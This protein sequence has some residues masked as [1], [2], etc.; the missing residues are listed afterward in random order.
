MEYIIIG[1]GVA[2]Q[3]AAEA[4]RK[5][6]PTTVITLI[7]KEPFGY[8]SRIFLP[9]YITRTKSL[10]NLILRDKAWYAQQNIRFL[11]GVTV[12]RIDRST[13]TV[14]TASTNSASPPS[15]LVNSYHYDKLL[16]ATGSNARKLPF[17]N[18]SV[19]GVFTLRNIADADEIYE[20]ITKHKV[21]EIFIIGGGLLGIELGY[22]LRDLHVHVTICEIA[23]Y[24]L[25]RQLDEP[26]AHILQ[27][28]L[29]S[30][31]LQI[32]TGVEVDRILGDQVVTGVRLKSGQE[33]PAGIVLQ[34]MGIIP[35]I[36]LA[37]SIG[38]PTDKGIIV[39]EYLQTIDNEIY[40]IGDC[41]QFRGLIWGI[42]PASLEQAKIA[43][44]HI[45]GQNPATYAGSFWNTRLK[46]AGIQLSCLGTP[47][48]GETPTLENVDEGN[49]LCK[50]V[51][52]D[53]NTLKSAILMEVGSVNDQYFVKNIGKKVNVDE[54]KKKLY[55]KPK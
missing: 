22:Q 20:Y 28:Y 43:V 29:E 41:V 17:S 36:A 37:K 32:L 13:H 30:Q 12:T 23:P 7:G 3:T 1:N 35:E 9:Q 50:K 45:L 10:T 31:Q 34:Q 42:I 15:S 55:D 14:Y 38:L 54:V 40:A 26:S 47:P 49:F 24:L 25:P 39:N 21:H 6:D 52:I 19:K 27:R 11:P 33:Y 51:I 48:S 5:E 18:P 53:Q 16:I 2:G 46:I 44:A 8:Y 4:L